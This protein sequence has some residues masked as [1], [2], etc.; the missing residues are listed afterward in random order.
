MGA[1]VTEAGETAEAGADLPTLC[2][3]WIGPKLPD[4]HH[5]CLKSWLAMGHPVRFYSYDPVENVPEGVQIC[6]AASVF[7]RSRLEDPELKMHPVIR[8]DIWRIAM[9]RRGLGIWCDAD[10]LLL[11]PIPRPKTLL[12]GVEHHGL[13][14]VAVM[15]WPKDHPALAEIMDVFD[16]VGLGPWSY[17]KPIWKRFQKFIAFQKRDFT[18]YPWN[19]WG[20]HAFE[21]YVKKFNLKDQQLGHRSF[22][23][24]EV[25]AGELFQ[26]RPFQHLLDDPEVIGL[27]CFYKPDAEFQAAPE[28][29]LI[30]WAKQRYA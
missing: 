19:H 17:A 11:R 29:S 12:L 26:A 14:C 5:L 20:R 30:H 25:Y 4:F 2:T 27:H 8:S 16:R 1:A 13:P 15:W 3:L 10:V 24:P 18:D 6:D 9:L 28:G 23:A 21:Y 22:F 7:P